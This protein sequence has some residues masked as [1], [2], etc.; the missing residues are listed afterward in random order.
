MH[1]II[2]VA[3]QKGG[4]A[5]TTTAI[6]LSASLAVAEL[7]V[8]LVDLD[9]QGNA[10]SGV[11][12][13]RETLEGSVY[14]LLIGRHPFSELIVRTEVPDLDLLPANIDLVG[15][16]VEL[17]GMNGRETILKERLKSN[18][19]RYDYVIID[20]PPSLGLLTL[21]ALTTAGTLLVPLQC[22]YFA[23]EGLALLMKTMKRVQASLNPGLDIEGILF[24]MYDGRN[25]LSNQVSQEIRT[26]FGNRVLKTI[27]PRNIT[28]AEA[29]S[30]GKPVLYYGA[31]SRGAKAYLALA[32]E[33]LRRGR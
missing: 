21:N 5:K 12:I 6:N 17:V 31:A 19:D 18:V 24:T 23:M 25:N 16:E 11:G 3:N 15:A 33:I 30:H 26:H 27:I 13:N 14:D 20:C 1:K 2:T 8:L 4:V 32:G 28:L 9:P 10:T 29:P 22:E 7:K